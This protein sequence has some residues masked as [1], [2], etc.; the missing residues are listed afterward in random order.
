VSSNRLALVYSIRKKEKK[1]KKFYVLFAV[2]A[3][4][5]LALSACGPAEEAHAQVA[6]GNT[7]GA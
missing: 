6:Y 5:A 4:V 2:L 3:I 1:M 7:G